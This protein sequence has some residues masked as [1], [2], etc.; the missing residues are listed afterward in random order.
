M[1]SFWRFFADF[2]F[3][4]RILKTPAIVHH[5]LI[6]PSPRDANTKIING[7]P[8]KKDLGYWNI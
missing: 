8:Q 2:R 5:K 4:N 6:L 1:E 3:P 7:D